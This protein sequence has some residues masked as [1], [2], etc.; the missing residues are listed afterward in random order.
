M[1]ELAG[2]AEGHYATGAL[3]GTVAD[4]SYSANGAF[5]DATGTLEGT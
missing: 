4:G 2:R 1:D 3:D 5:A